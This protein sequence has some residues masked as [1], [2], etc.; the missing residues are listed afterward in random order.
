MSL[1]QIRHEIGRRLRNLS[2]ARISGVGNDF[3]G[4]IKSRLTHL[5]IRTVFDVGA[6]IGMTTLEFSDEFP[7][8]TVYAFEPGTQ[9]FERMRSNLIGKP[10]VLLYNIGLSSAVGEGSLL[11]ESDHPSMARLV[12]GNGAGERE[13]VTLDTIDNFVARAQI[14]NI[15]LLKVD[16]EGHEMQV[17][18][19]AKKMLEEGR[20]SLI[21]F[22]TAIDPDLDYHTQFS[23]AFEFLRGFGYRLF[24]FYDQWEDPFVD[25]PRLRRFDAAMISSGLLQRP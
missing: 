9:N 18:A 5:T 10:D 13:R 2:R 15:D 24:G 6:H 4:D 22:E 7:D 19:G 17:F 25:S 16:V 20:I 8:A 12:Q 14:Q 23:T 11:C 1:L 3:V 21:R